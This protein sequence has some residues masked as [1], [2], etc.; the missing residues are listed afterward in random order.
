MN[1]D[2]DLLVIQRVSPLVQNK[3]ESKVP[4]TERHSIG[5]VITDLWFTSSE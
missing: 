5:A 1:I 3:Y 2:K 4:H